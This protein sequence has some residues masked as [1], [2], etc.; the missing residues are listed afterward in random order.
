MRLLR[1]GRRVIN[2]SALLE[3]VPTPDGTK[4]YLWMAAPSGE[5]GTF[6]TTLTGDEV[7]AF[8]AWLFDNS[9]LLTS[10]TPAPAAPPDDILIRACPGPGR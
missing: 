5:E 8:Y 4:V 3:A 7:L 1:F 10:I 9:E 6:C 2:I